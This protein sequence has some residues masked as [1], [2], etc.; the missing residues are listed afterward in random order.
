M[1]SANL[2]MFLIFVLFLTMEYGLPSHFLNRRSVLKG[3]NFSFFLFASF[4]TFFSP[5]LRSNLVILYLLTT[6]DS[7][8]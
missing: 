4:I 5:R 7:I 1:L 8:F 3:F 2:N 6:S